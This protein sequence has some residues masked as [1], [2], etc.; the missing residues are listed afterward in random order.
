MEDTEALYEGEHATARYHPG[1]TPWT[2]VLFEDAGQLP[3][4]GPK[5]SYSFIRRTGLSTVVISPN[6]ASWY[7]EAAMGACLEVVRARVGGSKLVTCGASMGG[8]GA[9]KHAG[10][11]GASHVV[12]M[13]PQFTLNRKRLGGRSDRLTSYFD[14][15]LHQA[16]DLHPRDLGDA[17]LNLI[18]DPDSGMDRRH[19]QMIGDSLD[20]RM[21]P[22]R[23]GGH[24]LTFLFGG[25]TE[26]PNLLTN[27]MND[28]LS[29]VHRQIRACKR[30]SVY[31][32]MELYR[33]LRRRRPKAAN[34]ALNA[35]VAIAPKGS[36]DRLQHADALIRLGRPELAHAELLEF[37]DAATQD[38]S[39]FAAA[40]G[41]SQAAVALGRPEE[42]LKWAEIVL[43]YAPE[44]ERHRLGLAVQLSRAGQFDKAEA[45]LTELG[46]EH[47]LPG[48]DECLSQVLSAQGQTDR[49]IVAG[50]GASAMSPNAHGAR[51][52]LASLLSRT[53]RRAE[54]EALHRAAA[55]AAPGDAGGWFELSRFLQQGGDKEEALAAARRA[56]DL[57][58]SDI[59]IRNHLAQLLITRGEA[60]EAE[61]LCRESVETWFGG[62]SALLLLAEA[63][64]HLQKMPQALAT[65]KLAVDREPA[66]AANWAALIDL[67]LRLNDW[68]GAGQTSDAADQ[69]PC[70]ATVALLSVQARLS[71]AIEDY[72]KAVEQLQGAIEKRPNDVRL[73]TALSK[74]LLAAGRVDEAEAAA[75]T[76]LQINAPGRRERSGNRGDGVAG[77][78]SGS[79]AAP[80]A[81]QA[82][83]GVN[84]GDRRSGASGSWLR[85]GSGEG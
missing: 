1:D 34:W 72:D 21:I 20:C 6:R 16:M 53:G 82:R 4:R 13:S 3:G 65:L 84:G 77:G 52:H 46:K 2:L 22:V 80:R 5:Q 28:D 85:Q 81:A 64:A 39:K 76:A 69:A 61:T 14:P 25:P 30:R 24:A 68:T 41:L 8:Y 57:D 50:I 51:R 54:G 7:P 74:C 10:R 49:A 31:Y 75:M 70:A 73:R 79:P 27:L 11:L 71:A 43:G 83:P 12:A 55:R 48:I 56:V 44:H 18:V 23:R 17:K 15:E 19:I 32:H 38:S 60:E 63:Q 40:K 66:S 62:S 59:P 35:A 67:Q 33:A 42:A 58:P 26:L 36:E 29:A 45:L 47:R 37:H 78:R 9:I